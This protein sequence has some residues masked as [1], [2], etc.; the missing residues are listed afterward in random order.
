ML[1][2][3]ESKAN[4]PSQPHSTILG[5]SSSS[6]SSST[7]ITSRRLSSPR[8]RHLRRALL[9]L[10]VLL[11]TPAQF[12]TAVLTEA[13]TCLSPNPDD[14]AKAGQSLDLSWTVSDLDTYM[15]DS[16]TATLLCLDVGSDQWRE[17]STLFQNQG[18]LFNLGMYSFKLPNC[19][20]TADTGAVRITAEGFSGSL[21]EDSSCVFNIQQAA[22]SF[23][24]LQ[25]PNPPVPSTG[26]TSII[27]PQIAT[28]PPSSQSTSSSSTSFTSTPQ[29]TGASALP[30]PSS[31]SGSEL[32]S[33]ESSSPSVGPSAHP[34][35]VPPVPAGGN[36]GGN[37]EGHRGGVE[38]LSDG[39]DKTLG[40]T[41]GSIGM[42]ACLAAVVVSLLVIRRRRRRRIEGGENTL[43]RSMGL[44]GA[45]GG[46]MKEAK[47]RIRL[48][49]RPTEGYFFQMEDEDEDATEFN[50]KDHVII[51]SRD[52]E[53]S[54]E[55]TTSSATSRAA[56]STTTE[57][58][59]VLQAPLQPTLPP[60][61]LLPNVKRRSSV[62]S[63]G[64]SSHSYTMSTMRSSLE[65]SSVVREYWAASMAAR[66]ERRMAD[67]IS[68]PG[69]SDGYG[70]EEG[71]IFG[72]QSRDSD[73]RMA[74]ILSLRTAGTGD[75][76]RGTIGTMR[77]QHS[78]NTFNSILDESSSIGHYRSLTMSFSSTPDSMMMSE[79]EFLDHLHIQQLHQFQLQHEQQYHFQYPQ[80]YGYERQQYPQ[81]IP[82]PSGHYQPSL[83]SYRTSSVP[84]LNS[85]NDPFKSFD[86]NAIIVDVDPFSDSRAVSRASVRSEEVGSGNR[87][88]L[89]T[90]PSDRSNTDLLRSFPDPPIL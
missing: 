22:T 11:S 42:A 58:A 90:G 28:V 65:T 32:G 63:A 55:G 34:T 4:S 9:S 23:P 69:M 40:A 86:S 83:N 30:S 44:G 39:K 21:Q 62:P 66:A 25:P 43:A 7:S 26:A 61:A 1:S 31:S 51:T 74:D 6:L 64:M 33:G 59:G 35:F 89:P 37:G 71:S 87:L 36:D 52:M 84:S 41:L 85:T 29:S 77:R 19:G 10:G 70:Y 67:G 45:E 57:G 38:G 2:G 12:R 18:L 72:D 53:A 16:L 46:V 20:P 73:S 14:T 76:F 5:S 81:Y 54:R 80:E 56:T 82:R 47:R 49:R 27:S 8:T 88:E 78:R 48:Q 79:E 50:E 13:V 24:P 68:S 60:V 17:I 15:F 75:S 3:T